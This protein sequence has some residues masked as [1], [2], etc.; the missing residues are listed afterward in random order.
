M[1]SENSC[2][3]VHVIGI[4]IAVRKLI[5]YKDWQVLEMFRR[6]LFYV[7]VCV[8]V[9]VCV[10]ERERERDTVLGLQLIIF[11]CLPIIGRGV[12]RKLEWSG[13]LVQKFQLYP[14]GTQHLAVALMLEVL[15]WA[16][17]K[18]NAAEIVCGENDTDQS[19]KLNR[20]LHIEAD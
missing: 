2:M 14:V 11:S 3:C 12:A 9:C 20:R 13:V 15:R 16:D 17:C 8:C 1:V 4:M 18:Q 10:W 19:V 5:A 6:V 7:C